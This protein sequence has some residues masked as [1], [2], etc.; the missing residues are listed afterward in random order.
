MDLMAITTTNAIIFANGVAAAIPSG[1]PVKPSMKRAR[2]QR[3]KARSHLAKAWILMLHWPKTGCFSPPTAPPSR[4][5][6]ARRPCCPARS[7][8]TANSEWWEDFLL[9]QLCC[10]SVVLIGYCFSFHPPLLLLLYL[11][12]LIVLAWCCQDVCPFCY[13]IEVNDWGWGCG[14]GSSQAFSTI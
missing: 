7:K 8:K 10:L 14:F 13:R 1:H 9:W 5:I 6:L 12:T 11:L 2:K 4:P 3:S